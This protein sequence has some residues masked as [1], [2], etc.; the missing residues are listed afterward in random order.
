MGTG[1][2]ES[3]RGNG[4]EGAR[5][6]LQ[7]DGLDPPLPALVAWDSSRTLVFDRRAFPV[8][9]LT[10]NRRVTIYVGKP[11]AIV[12]PTRPTQPFIFSG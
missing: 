4:R 12:Q 11:S 9:R 3:G 10:Y 1:R 5:V 2:E 7:L 6:G 8:L